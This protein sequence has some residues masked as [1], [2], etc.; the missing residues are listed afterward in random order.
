[1]FV[2]SALCLQ[3]QHGACEKSASTVLAL[4][5]RFVA[6]M[7]VPGAFR[8]DNG[9]EFTN[10]VFVDY[11]NNLGIWRNVT[12]PSN[13]QQNGPVESSITRALKAGHAARFGVHQ[14]FV[15]VRLEETR[16]CDDPVETSLWLLLWGSECL[17]RASSL[18]ND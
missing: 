8:T 14:L 16:G 9:T 3:R 15:D 1:M 11:C 10:A 7:G 2:D 13:P 5:K 12:T 6:D 4:M 18:V 17:N